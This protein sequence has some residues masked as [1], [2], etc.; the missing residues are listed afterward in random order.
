MIRS[1]MIKENI[2]IVEKLAEGHTKKWIAAQ[3]DIHPK[4]IYPRLA[5]MQQM[6][7]CVSE[8]HLVAKMLTLNLI[9]PKL[10]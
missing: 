2:W 8:C 1:K 10:I 7:E 4:S 6:H 3:L 9:N 5:T